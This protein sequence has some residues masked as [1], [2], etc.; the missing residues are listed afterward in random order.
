MIGT[1][2]VTHFKSMFHFYTCKHWKL[3]WFLDIFRVY[4]NKTM[5][6]N[7]LIEL[8]RYKFFI[9]LSPALTS[10]ISF[11]ALTIFLNVQKTFQTT[12]YRGALRTLT[13]IQDGAFCVNNKRL[14]TIHKKF[15]LRCC[16]TG[17]WMCLW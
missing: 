16:L 10:V 3:H 17:T 7:R 9:L 6:W 11:L 2:I 12:F 14:L 1:L 8:K 5:S 15:H 4:R 13:N